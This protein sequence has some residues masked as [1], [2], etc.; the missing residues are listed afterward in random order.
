MCE[1]ALTLL[2]EKLVDDFYTTDDRSVACSGEV[3]DCLKERLKALAPEDHGI[4]CFCGK[5]K[6]WKRAAR[7]CGSSPDSWLISCRTRAHRNHNGWGALLYGNLR[8][9]RRAGG[10]SPAF[11]CSARRYYR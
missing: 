9:S 8:K 2:A 4:F 1:L 3:E 11:L 10:G 5:R 6:R 7:N